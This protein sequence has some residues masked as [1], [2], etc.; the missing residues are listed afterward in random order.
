MI[1]VKSE[2][3]IELMR[4]AGRLA[5]STREL[6]LSGAEPGVTTLELDALAEQHIT[7]A[8]GI[9]SFKGYRGF[10]GSICASINGEVVHGIPGQR[11]LE[12][13]DVF[14]VDVGAILGGYH[15]DTAASV[16]IG[17]VGP[18]VRRLLEAGERALMAGIEQICPGNHLS[19]ISHAVQTYAEARGYSVV[20]D[21]AGHGIGR[22]M[23]EDPQIPNYGP[24]GRGPRLRRGMVL[25]IEPMLNEGTCRVVTADDG[26]TVYTA[27]GGLSVHFE[28]TV[29][30]TDEGWEILSICD[31]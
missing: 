17:D 30:V 21:Y 8:G 18:R 31:L 25:A 29:A 13:G 28:H 5:A 2:R 11:K 27:D 4:Q 10:P 1:I 23:H 12:E 6:V 19:D 15:G 7:A 24:P 26:W 22:D 9:P 16:A 20:R 14:S 3:E